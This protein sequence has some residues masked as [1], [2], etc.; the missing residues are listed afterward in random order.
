MLPI[1]YPIV[2]LGAV[3]KWL[4]QWIANPRNGFGLALI[5][6]YNHVHNAAYCNELQKSHSFCISFKFASY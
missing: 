1:P 2:L 4:R 3:A 5:L 6:A